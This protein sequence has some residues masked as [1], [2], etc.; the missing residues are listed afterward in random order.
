[1]EAQNRLAVQHGFYTHE[2]LEYYCSSRFSSQGCVLLV[3]I[4]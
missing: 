3:P 4:G 2:I 1:M